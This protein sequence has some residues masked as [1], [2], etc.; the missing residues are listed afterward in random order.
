MDNQLSIVIPTFNNSEQIIYLIEDLYNEFIDFNIEIIL[1]N[2]CSDDLTDVNIKSNIKKFKKFTYLRMKYNVGEID[3]VKTGLKFVNFNNI[4]IMDDDYQHSP[5]EAKSL[6][7]HG[8][9]STNKA[10]YVI[11]N[12]LKHSNL[13]VFFSKCFNFFMKFF[14]K[15]TAYISSFKFIKKEILRDFFESNYIDLDNFILNKYDVSTIKLKHNRSNLS[16]SRYSFIALINQFISR[17]LD[18]NRYFSIFIKTLIL[19]SFLY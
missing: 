3:A 17:Y 9:K 2:D 5:K 8:L 7:V 1:I 19:I 4:I 14:Q 6:A 18:F 15:K 12:Q 16:K 13:R 11:F 10:T